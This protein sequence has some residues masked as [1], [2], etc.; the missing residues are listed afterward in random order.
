[1]TD[2]SGGEV[3][4]VGRLEVMFEGTKFRASQVSRGDLII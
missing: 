4:G 1:M 2:F 3:P